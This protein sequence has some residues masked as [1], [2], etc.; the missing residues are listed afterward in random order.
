[1]AKEKRSLRQFTLTLDDDLADY[2]EN[3]RRS[4]G[5]ESSAAAARHLLRSVQAATPEEGAIRATRL[6]VYEEVK[7][8][9]LTRVSESLHNITT[10]VEQAIGLLGGHDGNQA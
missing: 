3:T 2:V 10:E 7:R 6:R 9:V 8:A 5:F 4:E 1:M